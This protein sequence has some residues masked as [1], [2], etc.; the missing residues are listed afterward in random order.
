MQRPEV[1][2]NLLEKLKE[3][4]EGKARGGQGPDQ[5]GLGLEGQLW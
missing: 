1:E 2:M 4:H 3:A 5:P